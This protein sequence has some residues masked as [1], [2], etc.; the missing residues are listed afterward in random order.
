MLECFGTHIFSLQIGST[1]NTIAFSLT[2]LL[3]G[4]FADNYSKN[5]IILYTT[6]IFVIGNLIAANAS[7]IY[8]FWLS[9]LINGLSN[10]CIQ[11]L[12]PIIIIEICGLERSPNAISLLY[13]VSTV[14]LVFTPLISGMILKSYQWQYL[15][16]I[17]SFIAFALYLSIWCLF[18]ININILSKKKINIK[19]ILYDY[20]NI[21]S[22]LEFMLYSIIPAVIICALISYNTNIIYFLSAINY[23]SFYS[24]LY[25]TLPPSI[26]LTIR[27]VF[28]KYT[29]KYKHQDKL[30]L[31]LANLGGLTF[32]ILVII[33]EKDINNEILILSVSFIHL[34]LTYVMPIF[35]LKAL[36][37]F[38][39]KIATASTIN[40]FVKS[41]II[42]TGIC[43]SGF[44]YNGSL[45][46]IA[47]LIDIFLF[48]ATSSYLIH[49]LIAK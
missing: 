3:I 28:N 12:C 8:I 42:A 39:T 33:P 49:L 38:T 20:Y 46:S 18:P 19:S 34:G 9:Q 6:L 41:I 43:I 27:F 14:F 4:P 44:T 40:N 17:V 24:S 16:Y 36:S 2:T 32:T 30:G 45:T 1:I 5:K 31:A 22:S 15:F 37:K 13:L 23:D 26:A 25:L 35:F 48:I 47:I 21:L 7:N 29:I 11:V 10:G